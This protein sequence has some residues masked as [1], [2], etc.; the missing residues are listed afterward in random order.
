[1]TKPQSFD[2]LNDLLDGQIEGMALV[3]LSYFSKNFCQVPHRCAR[4]QQRITKQDPFRGL[5][6]KQIKIPLRSQGDH[7]PILDLF[8]DH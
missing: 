3:L 1:M 2:L 4:V 7:Q 8:K 5:L 6:L